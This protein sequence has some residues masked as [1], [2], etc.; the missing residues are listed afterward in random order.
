MYKEE[1]GFLTPYVETLLRPFLLCFIECGRTACA[2]ENHALSA[3]GI[4]PS[5]G[6]TG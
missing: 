1:R 2:E 3:A 5:E 4:T 6:E